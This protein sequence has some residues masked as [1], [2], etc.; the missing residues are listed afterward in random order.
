MSGEGYPKIIWLN[1]YLIKM[2]VFVPMIFIEIALLIIALVGEFAPS[3]WNAYYIA[4]PV[5]FVASFV[6]YFVVRG[7]YRARLECYPDKIVVVRAK[8]T[9]TYVVDKN[10]KIYFH[11]S[12]WEVVPA[13]IPVPFRTG[14][15]IFFENTAVPDS[16]KFSARLNYKNFVILADVYPNNVEPKY[17]AYDAQ[18]LE[19][20]IKTEEYNEDNRREL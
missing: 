14:D 11:K 5:I 6:I 7:L 20:E 9:I 19:N 16:P 13:D 3:D 4:A 10:F 17:R 1:R 18:D 8:S 12:D 15:E 2:A